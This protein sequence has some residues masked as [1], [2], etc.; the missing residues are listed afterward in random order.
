[1][2]TGLGYGDAVDNAI[3]F[4]YFEFPISLLGL[5]LTQPNYPPGRK[6]VSADV[7]TGATCCNPGSIVWTPFGPLQSPPTR[8]GQSIIGTREP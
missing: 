2:F 1:M 3:R 5:V 7:S 8:G 4:L 6:G